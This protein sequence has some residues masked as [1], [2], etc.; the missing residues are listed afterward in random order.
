MAVVYM[1]MLLK[2][3]FFFFLHLCFCLV[4]YFHILFVPQFGTK[5]KEFALSNPDSTSGHTC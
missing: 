5:C 4:Q 1:C 3:F 2:W